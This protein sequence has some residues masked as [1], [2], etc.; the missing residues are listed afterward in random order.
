MQRAGGE[1]PSLFFSSVDQS[2]LSGGLSNSLPTFSQHARV[3]RLH[4]GMV[5]HLQ[6]VGKQY[7]YELPLL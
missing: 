6:Y 5:G 3:L 2:M 1:P 4:V 7:V